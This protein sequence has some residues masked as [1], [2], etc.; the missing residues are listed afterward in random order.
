MPLKFYENN[1]MK[2]SGCAD[3]MLNCIIVFVVHLIAKPKVLDNKLEELQ[4]TK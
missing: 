3:V 2:R 4:D 1:V